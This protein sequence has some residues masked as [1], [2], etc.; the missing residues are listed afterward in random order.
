MVRRGSTFLAGILA[1]L[2]AAGL[3]YLVVS[4]PRGEPVRLLPPPTAR[5]LQVHVVGAVRTPGVYQLPR[6]A[7]V[8]DALA[9]AGGP[10]AEAN[11]AGINLAAGLSDSQQVYVPSLGET[12]QAASAVGSASIASGDLRLNPNTASAP[13][14][15]GLPGIGPSLAQAI[16]E[17]RES[18][19][20]FQQPE[21]LL[22]V[23]GIGPAK[24]AQI[25]D[26]I[27]LP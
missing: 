23:P 24:L 20:P 2:L 12:P 3:L 7:I 13:E 10:A 21:D 22:Q 18:H 16:I 4:K 15:E 8:Q 11:L 19:G 9:A 26:L 6:G 17:Y 5:P 1:G 14:L 25:E 27:V